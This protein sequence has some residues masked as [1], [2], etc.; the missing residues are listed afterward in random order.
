[1]LL[2]LRFDNLAVQRDLEPQC[3]VREHL[4]RKVEVERAG[5]VLCAGH[6]PVAQAEHHSG[7]FVGLGSKGE[8]HLSAAD[9]PVRDN[10]LE[11]DLGG[12]PR[13]EPHRVLAHLG[14]VDGIEHEPKGE[15]PLDGPV[16]HAPVNDERKGLATDRK[17]R[18]RVHDAH[19]NRVHDNVDEHLGAGSVAKQQGGTRRSARQ[20][21]GG[22][23]SLSCT[24][25]IFLFFFFLVL[26]PSPGDPDDAVP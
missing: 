15:R 24:S 4:R 11:R 7:A 10:L 12:V 18:E 3:G 13:D 5:F 20:L 22:M 26:L 9:L 25:C 23:L 19:G 8:K 16:H 17:L 6:R 14:L 21:P 1:M 2:P